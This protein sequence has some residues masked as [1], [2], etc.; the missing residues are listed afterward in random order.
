[1]FNKITALVA[2]LLLVPSVSSA[3]TLNNTQ[4]S[5]DRIFKAKVIEIIEEKTT[6]RADGSKITQQN[7]LLKGLEGEWQN[8]DY[9]YF[10]ISDI[11]DPSVNT[12]KVGDKV[13]VSEIKNVDGSLDYYIVDLVRTGY[14]FWLALIFI[15][16]VLII[17]KK[18]G[19]KSLIGLVLSFVVIIKFILP[20]IISGSSPLVVG[21]LGA[22]AILAI[23]I[24]LTDG[25]S[26][27]SHVAV[28]SV[29]CTLVITFVLSWVFTRLTRLTGLAEE[30]A[31]FLLGSNNVM[32]DFRGLLLTGILIGTVGVLDDVIVGQVETVRQIKK[33]NPNLSNREVYKS[34]YEVGSS[35]LGA[36]VNTLFLTYTGA[37]LPLLIL[38]YLNPTGSIS[39]SQFINNELIATEVVRTLVGSIGIALAMPISTSLAAVWMKEK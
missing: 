37:S 11:S 38:F 14:L 1:M 17:G 21:V 12:Y 36:I 33:A 10:G 3:Q 4:D 6:Q 26:R 16:V 18:K 23:I 15:S 39:F 7:I 34:A 2:F 19:A 24:Y 32:V 29:F 20:K 27:K 8:K 28:A 35:H 9:Q 13:M 31:I 30:E 25:W 5:G 22:L